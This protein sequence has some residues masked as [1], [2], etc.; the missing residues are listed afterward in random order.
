MPQQL[1]NGHELA[2]EIKDSIA[3]FVYSLQGPRPN[4]AIVLVGNRPDSELYVRLKQQEAK[5]V[6]IDTHLYRCPE[7]IKEQELIAII[8]FLNNDPLIDGLLVQLPLPKHLNP[9]NIVNIIRADKDVDG[10]T[11]L[12]LQKLLNNDP[13]AIIPP[14]FG[15]ILR[16]IIERQLDL[17][18]KK[19][20]IL[21]N[22]PIFSDNLALLLKRQGATVSIFHEVNK[23]ASQAIEEANLLISALGQPL[24]VKP[25]ELPENYLII[26]IGI[27][28]KDHK[29]YGDVDLKSINP[30]I[31]GWATPVPGGVGPLTIAMALYNTLL[32]YQQHH[33]QSRDN[34]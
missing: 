6:G 18:N 15:V 13:S 34:K 29:V 28:K 3:N 20:V 27:T 19:A 31:N 30:T 32:L 14:V 25:K 17:T 16:I 1:I 8:N 24:I 11:P 12:N 23:T 10:F 33:A 22:S 7:D 2:E 5:K 26:D 21:G 9:D 4:L